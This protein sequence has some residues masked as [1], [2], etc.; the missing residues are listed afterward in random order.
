MN[1]FRPARILPTLLAALSLGPLATAHALAAT[2]TPASGD[3][4]GSLIYRVYLPA[5]APQSVALP[6]LT[7]S[8][9]DGRP[10]RTLTPCTGSASS[11]SGTDTSCAWRLVVSGAQTSD[12]RPAGLNVLYPDTVSTYWVTFFPADPAQTITVKGVYPDARYMSFNA[13]DASGSSYEVNGMPSGLYDAAIQPD[14]GALNP[15]QQSGAAGGAYTVQLLASP[16]PKAPNTLPLPPAS[17]ASLSSLPLPCKGTACPPADTFVRIDT[18]GLY[19][20]VDNAYVSALHTPQAGEVLVI[21]GKLPSTVDGAHPQPWPAGATQLRYWSVCNNVYLPPYPVLGCADD[22][23]V[24]VDS[25]GDYTVVTSAPE[26]RPTNATAA[27]GVVWLSNATV[28]PTARH[29]VL[30]RNM[31]PN[32]FQQAVQSVPVNSSPATTQAIM[33]AYYPRAWR[34]SKRRFEQ[35]G[36]QACQAGG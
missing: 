27:Q 25:Q 15:W 6:T 31:L 20:N 3:G 2:D 19:P 26:D 7:F 12:G 24:P 10:S 29:L 35:G 5:G 14:A 13:Y 1:A 30:V 23:Q 28:L 18:G 22:D 32:G 16:D 9:S 34:C 33:H 11:T 8:Y 17:S 4:S 36:W 21:R